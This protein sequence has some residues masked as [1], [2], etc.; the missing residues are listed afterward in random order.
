MNI[1]VVD[2]A[3]GAL[4]KAKDNRELLLVCDYI[5]EHRWKMLPKEIKRLEKIL[6][7]RCTEF[8]IKT[9]FNLK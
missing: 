1:G 6:T 7:A 2:L 9:V 5:D 4:E 8:N 3:A